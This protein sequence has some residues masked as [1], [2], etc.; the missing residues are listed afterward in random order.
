MDKTSNFEKYRDSNRKGKVLYNGDEIELKDL[1][2]VNFYTPLSAKFIHSVKFPSLNLTLSN[3][4]TFTSGS[5][6]IL[7]S[8]DN[9]KR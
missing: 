9:N 1:P 7:R 3:F 8:F 5:E 4:L 2:I 6:A